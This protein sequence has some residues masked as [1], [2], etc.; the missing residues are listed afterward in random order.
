MAAA[1]A[2]ISGPLLDFSNILGGVERSLAHV[3]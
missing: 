3:E 2:S 1:R